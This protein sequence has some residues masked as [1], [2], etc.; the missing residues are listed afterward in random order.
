MKHLHYII[1]VIAK[2]KNKP[3][4]ISKLNEI[5]FLAQYLILVSIALQMT[6]PSQTSLMEYEHNADRHAFHLNVML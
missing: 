1:P 2:H 6:K 5:S 4:S 3:F